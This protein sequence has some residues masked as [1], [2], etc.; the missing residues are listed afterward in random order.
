MS[1]ILEDW[2]DA[3]AVKSENPILRPK[4]RLYRRSLSLLILAGSYGFRVTV[5]SQQ[6]NRARRRRKLNV[7]GRSGINSGFGGGTIQAALA[8]TLFLCRSMKIG[9]PA[10]RGEAERQ[11]FGELAIRGIGLT[12]FSDNE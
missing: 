5:R 9:T 10:E 12:V 7:N 11:L 3:R 2:K 4:Y 8:L 6:Q 1:K